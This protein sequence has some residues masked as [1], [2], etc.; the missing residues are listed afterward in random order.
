MDGIHLATELLK[1]IPIFF[2]IFHDFIFV[3]VKRMAI[4][5]IAFCASL[6]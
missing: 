1:K 4:F 5:V 6:N 3:L 2:K